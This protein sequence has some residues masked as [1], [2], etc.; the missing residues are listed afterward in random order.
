[1]SPPISEAATPLIESG[2][3]REEVEMAIA[4]RYMKAMREK[5][6]QFP[7]VVRD[8]HIDFARAVL[9][10]A[11]YSLEFITNGLNETGKG[12]FCDVTGLKLPK[13]IGASRKALMEWA[14]TD[15]KQDALRK[16]QRLLKINRDSVAGQIGNMDEFVALIDGYYASGLVQVIHMNRS[17]ILANRE[18]TSGIN[19]SEKGFRGSITRPYI[20]AFLKVQ[21][22]RVEVREI[23]EPQWLSP[24][25]KAPDAAPTLP[26]PTSQPVQIGFGF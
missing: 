6:N 16:A 14:G 3:P 22:L 18:G 10:R 4:T 7:D 17:Y 23:Q 13:A 15:P 1:M 11:F 8:Y 26:A 21:Q 12:V 19:L 20:D 2:L 25:A 9:D 5:G 24:K